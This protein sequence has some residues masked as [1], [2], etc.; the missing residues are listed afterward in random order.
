MG[1]LEVACVEHL[2]LEVAC[3]VASLGTEASEQ[4]SD[5]DLVVDFVH[6]IHW[7]VDFV[8]VHD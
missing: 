6:E 8:F 7:L 4:I 5:S 2:E 3:E 1:C